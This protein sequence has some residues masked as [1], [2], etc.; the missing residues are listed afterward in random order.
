MSGEGYGGS[1]PGEGVGVV[2]ELGCMNILHTFAIKEG[3]E[4]ERDV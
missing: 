2:P 4:K 3:S 1:L